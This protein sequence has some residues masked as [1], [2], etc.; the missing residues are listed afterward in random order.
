M[1]PLRT[2]TALETSVDSDVSAWSPPREGGLDPFSGPS[3]SQSTSAVSSPSLVAGSPTVT[4][5]LRPETSPV[6]GTS[7][8]T[9]TESAPSE[10]S[11]LPPVSVGQSSSSSP[12][13]PI[14]VAIGVGGG[15]GTVVIIAVI[16]FFARKA[17]R[18]RSKAGM[19]PRLDYQHELEEVAPADSAGA[20]KPQPL[21]IQRVGT[22]A[23]IDET[24]GLGDDDL[25]LSTSLPP[26]R[27]LR[28]VDREPA[29]RR[30][31]SR[32]ALG[33]LSSQGLELRAL[34]PRVQSPQPKPPTRPWR[35]FLDAADYELM[36]GMP[37]PLSVTE[38]YSTNA[39]EGSVDGYWQETAS[40][41]EERLYRL[42]RPGHSPPPPPSP[43]PSESSAARYRPD[44]SVYAS[45]AP[46]S[47][48]QE[49]S[50]VGMTPVGRDFSGGG[51]SQEVQ[52]SPTGT[53]EDTI[54]Q[55]SPSPIGSG[56]PLLHR[57]TRVHQRDPQP[58]DE[59]PLEGHNE[60]EAAQGLSKAAGKLPAKDSQAHEAPS[61]N[62][63]DNPPSGN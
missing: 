13:V 62:P 51:T 43:G 1:P 50:D 20:P 19:V 10:S 15:L 21:R 6:T 47:R 14:N 38:D 8:G 33:A 5:S 9:T 7:A 22:S 12:G 48:I 52:G 2:A 24:D 60:E 26:P 36:R 3:S 18:K 16:V 23:E 31:K 59:Q 27:Q 28:T 58:A 49:M 61:G 30:N 63:P 54:D 25:A 4:T 37:A 29:R 55:Q 44:P 35:G 56:D 53:A 45:A 40:L 39:G 42:R 41:R 34:T 11:S 32:E 17:L 46:M 57:E